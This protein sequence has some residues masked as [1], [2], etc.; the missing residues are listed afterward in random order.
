METE[1]TMS[2]IL[3]FLKKEQDLAKKSNKVLSFYS[4]G[5]NDLIKFIEYPEKCGKWPFDFV[6]MAMEALKKLSKNL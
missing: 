6:L 5:V 2:E 3:D 4:V 1:K